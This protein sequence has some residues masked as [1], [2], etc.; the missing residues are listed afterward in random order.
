MALSS[1]YLSK[2]NNNLS[3]SDEYGPLD[4]IG[5]IE[6]L[7][8]YSQWILSQ[9]TMIKSFVFKGNKRQGLILVSHIERN[10]TFQK[11]KKISK[12]SISL[13]G[14]E[15]NLQLY[16]DWLDEEL[17]IA[18]DQLVDVQYEE[19]KGAFQN[20]SRENLLQ[21]YKTFNSNLEAKI[22]QAETK[23]FA[24]Q[25]KGQEIRIS[26]DVLRKR[27]LKYLWKL[28][29]DDITTRSIGWSE[30][31]ITIHTALTYYS[32]YSTDATREQL[33]EL[34]Q[35]V[36][37]AIVKE[38]LQKSTLKRSEKELD[39]FITGHIGSFWDRFL[40]RRTETQENLYNLNTRRL[41]LQKSILMNAQQ[42]GEK[43]TQWE[44]QCEELG[45]Q[46]FKLMDE[47]LFE[48]E[49]TLDSLRRQQK[50]LKE[51]DPLSA[52]DTIQLDFINIHKRL[53][54]QGSLKLKEEQ[55][56]LALSLVSLETL[57]KTTSSF[58]AGQLQSQK[59]LTKQNDWAKVQLKKIKSIPKMA[60]AVN[61]YCDSFNFSFDLV[62]ELGRLVTDWSKEDYSSWRAP[63]TSG[64]IVSTLTQYATK[65][66]FPIIDYLLEK[67]DKTRAIHKSLKPYDTGVF[68]LQFV[69]GLYF[70][71]AETAKAGGALVY[72]AAIIQD[73]KRKFK[74]SSTLTIQGGASVE[75]L[76]MCEAKIQLDLYKE[77][78]QFEFND[79]FQWAAW[80]AH[81]WARLSAMYTA[82][83][84]F[85]DPSE[86]Q[87]QY[88]T[89]TEHDKQ[90]LLSAAQRAYSD[91]EKIKNTIETVSNLLLETPPIK[92]STQTGVLTSVSVD[93]KV[94]KFSGIGGASTVI[95]NTSTLYKYCYQGEGERRQFI[96]YKKNLRQTK[97][98]GEFSLLGWKVGADYDVKKFA[99]PVTGKAENEHTVILDINLSGI[100]SEDPFKFAEKLGALAESST[101]PTSQLVEGGTKLLE[102]M[103]ETFIGF[104]VPYL[105]K[106]NS[107]RLHYQG[108][109]LPE[110]EKASLFGEW[111]ARLDY[112]TL[113]FSLLPLG[114]RPKTVPTSQWVLLY[115][116]KHAKKQL[117]LSKEIPA[118]ALPALVSL[119]SGMSIERTFD[120]RLGV[121]SFDYLFTIYHGLMTRRVDK[122][123]R[124]DS[125]S[126]T[127]L[128]NS[129]WKNRIHNIL[130]LCLYAGASKL[131]EKEGKRSY[132]ELAIASKSSISSTQANA[133]H[134]SCK[135][136]NADL[137]P[138]KCLEKFKEK[139]DISTLTSM[140]VDEIYQ[141]KEGFINGTLKQTL[142]AYFKKKSEHIKLEEEELWTR[143]PDSEQYA[144]HFTLN[145]VSLVSRTVKYAK[146]SGRRKLAEAEELISKPRIG[147]KEGIA[148]AMFEKD[149]EKV[150]PMWKKKLDTKE[151]KANLLKDHEGDATRALDSLSP[152][153]YKDLQ[154]LKETVQVEAVSIDDYIKEERHIKPLQ[155]LNSK[156]KNITPHSHSRVWGRSDF[157]QES[158]RQRKRFTINH[159]YATLSQID[160]RLD[161]YHSITWNKESID[162][163]L[164]VLNML[165]NDI[166]KQMHQR[167]NSE[168][169]E[170]ILHLSRQVIQEK[171]NIEEVKKKIL[172][173]V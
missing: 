94:G 87:D 49:D 89:I 138:G 54:E 38:R 37:R 20:K 48:I 154:N 168:R 60:K 55:E 129:Y 103:L 91:N 56:Q 51:K 123:Q 57:L 88:G 92:R 122:K 62:L 77:E 64:Q 46:H 106:A 145:P 100:L 16:L 13:E 58:V 70:G 159:R 74:A 142:E 73:D 79:V 150:S 108:F 116:R 47:E 83:C 10:E 96:E 98:K 23:F 6:L 143:V 166:E 17:W 41:D 95:P 24:V 39:D 131:G 126:G 34:A 1:E 28:E 164:E 18:Q 81:K 31:L 113:D 21:D 99:N 71:I 133:L 149:L 124:P 130:H 75:F 157:V 29:E 12:E 111:Q 110:T 167:P 22:L 40:H 156:K 121:D 7:E 137:E 120:E 9:R 11:E 117:Q 86:A 68:Q 148:L 163:R 140:D 127:E 27:A 114:E 26:N 162:T 36:R 97:Q 14:L 101:Y 170:S 104:L 84:D 30:I 173:N 65:A 153:Q 165:I 118:G 128:W 78:T 2:L 105:D 90:R 66:R 80:F 50:T 67:N 25:K 69:V 107:H 134:Q 43:L 53:L 61:V 5:E 172:M 132:Y 72:N 33:K 45:S 160:E 151:K 44:K 4:S 112:K 125:Q 109:G 147:A 52:E 42:A 102:G 169:K 171:K 115:W 152:Q 144:F 155:V 3:F 93:A 35:D 158:D 141:A 136:L 146:E 59:S 135:V 161:S 119:E 63:S 82:W 139:R 15:E 85:I 8:T 19:I 76:K 32:R